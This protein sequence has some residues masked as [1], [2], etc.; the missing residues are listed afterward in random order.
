MTNNNHLEN[1]KQLFS[2]TDRAKQR[3]CINLI[4][5]SATGLAIKTAR[6][7]KHTTREELSNAVGI[8]IQQL[9][10]IEEGREM[11]SMTLLKA[12]CDALK[13]DEEKNTG[14]EYKL[15]YQECL[16][17]SLEHLLFGE[18]MFA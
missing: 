7:I 13:L 5:C 15:T 6:Y 16:T 1:L 3:K 9:Q 12:M 2:E 10:A 11:P 4:I 8:E 18:Q 14:E 17:T